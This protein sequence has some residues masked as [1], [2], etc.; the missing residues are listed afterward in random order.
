MVHLAQLSCVFFEIFRDRG[1]QVVLKVKDLITWDEL[2]K[3][4][5][6]EIAPSIT[7]LKTILR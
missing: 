3:H 5:L 6:D 2:K 7:E 4:I 1:Q